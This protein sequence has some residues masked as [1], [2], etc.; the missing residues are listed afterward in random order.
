MTHNN[1]LRDEDYISRLKSAIYEQY[2]IAVIEIT[3]AT[4]GYYGETWKVKGD[5]G[6]YYLKMDYLPFHQ[7]N[8]SRVC[9]L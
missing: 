5:C 7:K 8:F 4:R 6:I 1:I 3:P 9:P 2:G